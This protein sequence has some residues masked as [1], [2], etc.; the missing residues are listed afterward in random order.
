MSPVYRDAY[1]LVDP[2]TVVLAQPFDGDGEHDGVYI[3]LLHIGV[4]QTLYEVYV[5]YPTNQERNQ[6]FMKI[7]QLREA[8]GESLPLS[9]DFDLD[10]DEGDN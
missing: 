6:A 9:C 4:G 10:T 5:R 3:L 1:V 8:L 2:R 7:A